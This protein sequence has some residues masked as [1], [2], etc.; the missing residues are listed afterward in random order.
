[1]RADGG[2]MRLVDAQL[3]RQLRTER[4]T[5]ASRAVERRKDLFRKFQRLDRLPV[6]VLRGGVIE[7]GGRC[8]GVFRLLFARQEVAQKIGHEQKRL[9]RLQRRVALLLSAVEL[10]DGV[11]I[12]GRD[13]RAG[14]ER[15]KING[16]PDGLHI[17]IDRV[18]IRTGIGEQVT[19]FVE[20]TV[21]HAPSV[22][23]DAVKLPN[24]RVF[25]R[26]KA[27]LQLVVEIRQ[28][29]VEHAVHLNIVVFKPVQLAHRDLLAVELT[30]DCA[31]VA[32]TEIKRQ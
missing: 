31:A 26:Q 21:V 25:E 12:H 32:C 18:S 2:E 4:S 3:L 20:Q 30:K 11:E 8:L 6:P 13:A 29:P 14:K 10:I 27:L 17:R 7:H 5:K 9:R 15:R 23:A 16:L 22:D 28:I 24:V 19:V 1:M